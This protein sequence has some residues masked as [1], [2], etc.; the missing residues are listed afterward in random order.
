MPAVAREEGQSILT[1]LSHLRQ[2]RVGV[3][4]DSPNWAETGLRCL[5]G[6]YQ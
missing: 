2:R 3:L 4:M 5:L 1:G 6:D